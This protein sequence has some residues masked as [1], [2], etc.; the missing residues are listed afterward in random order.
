MPGHS[1]LL[2][3]SPSSIASAVAPAPAVI[4]TRPMSI[5]TLRELLKKLASSTSPRIRNTFNA[6]RFRSVWLAPETVAL[7]TQ[8]LATTPHQ[9]VH[10]SQI[11]KNGTF[12]T[13]ARWLASIAWRL[14]SM[15]VDRLRAAF[16][17]RQNCV[18][19]LAKAFSRRTMMSALSTT[20]FLSSDGVFLAAMNTG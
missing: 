2:H 11:S 13:L 12:Q 16:M 20:K 4:P 14:K 3:H 7:T 19:S 6:H 15:C 1:L 5:C 17:S 10:Q 8:P 9:C 18:P